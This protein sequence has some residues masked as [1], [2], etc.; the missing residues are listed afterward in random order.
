V[1]VRDPGIGL[2]PDQLPRLFDRFYRVRETASGGDELGVGLYISK[3]LIEAHGGRIWA[4]SAG[5]GQ[6]STFAFTLPLDPALQQ[7]EDAAGDRA[8][9]SSSS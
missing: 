1:S 5:P 6:G 7:P 2:A 4:E 3:H 8:R 9:R